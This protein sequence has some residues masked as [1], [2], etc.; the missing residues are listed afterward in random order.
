MN[1]DEERQGRMRDACPGPRRD[2]ADGEACQVC[3]LMQ[4]VIPRMSAPAQ[5]RM[6]EE[7]ESLIGAPEPTKEEA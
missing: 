5:R 6:V 3:R 4:M 2:D 1:S 7:F